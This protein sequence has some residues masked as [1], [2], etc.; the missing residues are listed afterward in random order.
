MEGWNSSNLTDTNTPPSTPKMRGGVCFFFSLAPFHKSAWFPLCKDNEFSNSRFSFF[1][2]KV[3]KPK[4]AI[5]PYYEEPNFINMADF[6]NK[7]PNSGFCTPFG[8]NYH[9]KRKNRTEGLKM[10]LNAPSAICLQNEQ[11]HQKNFCGGNY[12]TQQQPQAAR[13]AG[14]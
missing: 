2:P 5:F 12:A 11:R 7:R 6:A 14:G 3:C 8:T 4:K 13:R 10:P 9:P 1:H